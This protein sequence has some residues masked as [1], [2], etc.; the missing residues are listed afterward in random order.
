MLE[1]GKYHNLRI[2]RISRHGA[3]LNYEEGAPSDDVLLPIKQLPN[4]AAIGDSIRV[5]VYM[6]SEDRIIST[7]RKPLLTLGECGILEVVQTTRIGAFLDWGLEKDLFLPFGNQRGKIHKGDKL[8]VV[9]I[10]D[11]KSR[12]CATMNVYELLSSETPY[13]LNDKVSGMVYSVNDKVGAFVAVEGRYHGLIPSREIISG[14]K[15]GDKVETRVSNIRKDGKLILSLRKKAYGEIDRDAE[16]L[17]FELRKGKGYLPYG[18][19]TNPSMI[20]KRFGIS[21]AAF[22]RAVGR[23]LKQKKIEI[24]PKGIMLASGKSDH[25]NRD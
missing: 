7:I 4:E 9:L 18:D 3:Y 21:K 1:T 19:K 6:D 15:A 17:M 22:K 16:K 20:K 23:L 8:C 2:L 14:L 25:G 11:E 24:T 5:F 13:K 10:H 12:L